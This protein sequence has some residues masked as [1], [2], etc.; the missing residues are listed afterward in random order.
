MIA[1]WLA[2]TWQGLALTLTLGGALRLFPRINASTRCALWWV[3]LVAIG[4]MGVSPDHASNLSGAA[5]APPLLLVPSPA[6]AWLRIAM[7]TWAAVALL[8]VLRVFVGVYGILAIRRDCRPLPPDIENL[9]PLWLE[10]RSRGR[11][12]ELVMSDA[13]AGA[14]VLG[15]GRPRIAL[16]TLLVEVLTPKELDQVVLHEYAHVRR[17]DDWSKLAQT[18]LQVVMWVHPAVALVS[19]RL[20]LERE[21]ACDQWV[22][23]RTGQTKAYALCL[24]RADEARSA[25]SGFNRTAGSMLR[26][27]LFGG[28]QDLI[29]R[30]DRLLALDKNARARVSRLAVA[31]G[32]CVV[33]ATAFQLRLFPIVAEV[34]EAM[35]LPNL[36]APLALLRAPAAAHP[37]APDLDVPPGDRKRMTRVVTNAPRTDDAKIS[38]ELPGDV[39][40]GTDEAPGDPDMPEITATVYEAGYSAAAAPSVVRDRERGWR[41]AGA[42]IGSAGRKT[43]VG[44]AA[45]F[46]RAGVSLARRF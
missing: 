8:S 38:V 45:I 5:Q 40:A 33:V 39:A 36:P 7:A 10:A 32:A 29:R 43:G 26:P 13:L 23:A 35:W 46:T 2:W 9:L 12:A 16:P 21:M 15:F 14:T 25:V 20:N 31:G 19:R 28:K 30:V 27:A 18:V 37:L 4:A 42:A 17:W 11:Q 1:W 34:S 44:M 24:A 3:V 6:D 22:V 41:Q